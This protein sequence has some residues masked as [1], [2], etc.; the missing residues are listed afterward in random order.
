MALAPAVQLRR[1][2]AG[3]CLS[4]EAETEQP[5]SIH[6]K[7]SVNGT[8]EQTVDNTQYATHRGKQRCC[9]GSPASWPKN[10][11]SQ[12]IPAGVWGAAKKVIWASRRALPSAHMHSLPAQCTWTFDVAATAWSMRAHGFVA[13]SAAHVARIGDQHLWRLMEQIIRQRHGTCVVG[14]YCVRCGRR[15]T[16]SGRS[17]NDSSCCA[18]DCALAR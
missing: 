12:C 9:P 13:C 18:R 17:S 14:N 6:F 4:L 15:S 5:P 7:G 16:S 3:A 2:L 11:S 1:C 10:K 8:R